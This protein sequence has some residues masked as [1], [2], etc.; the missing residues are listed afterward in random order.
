M[1][2]FLVKLS[3]HKDATELVRAVGNNATVAFSYLLQIG[4]YTVKGR[5]NESKQM[6]QFKMEY[7]LFF[8]FT[9]VTS[10]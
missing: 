7:V 4:E 5:C 1:P 3:L 6:V 9:R 8:K 10:Q 2:E